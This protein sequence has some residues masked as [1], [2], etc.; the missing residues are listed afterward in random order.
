MC[1]RAGPFLGEVE[2][3]AVVIEA[4]GERRAGEA[5]LAAVE[6]DVDDQQLWCRLL[7]G[8]D[9]DPNGTR[10]SRNARH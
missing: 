1:G 7:M 9:A 3:D 10:T 2:V 4:I 8:V 5:F 6:L